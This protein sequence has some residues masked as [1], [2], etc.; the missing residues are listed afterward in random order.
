MDKDTSGATQEETTE[1]V[2]NL[3][4]S[5]QGEE[6]GEQT[7]D[8]RLKDTQRKLHEVTQERAKEKQEL[9]ERLARLEGALQATQVRPEPQPED[10]LAFLDDQELKEKF[11]DDPERPIGAMKRV[12]SEIGKIL[13]MRDQA[14]LA[15][16]EQMIAERMSAKQV[17]PAIRD[18]MDSLRK[19]PDFAQMDDKTLAIFAKKL[20]PKSREY[21]GNIGGS[22]AASGT[23]DFGKSEVEEV[24]KKLMARIYGED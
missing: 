16:M 21:P 18:T 12:A 17:D 13:P 14:L 7:L 4:L 5:N 10:P 1:V 9:I 19:D 11:F 6:D 3:E 23:G 2:E 20:K 22:R 8:K 15:R 24:A